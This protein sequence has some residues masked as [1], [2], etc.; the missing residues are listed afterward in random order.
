ME[1]F[2]E[3][4]ETIL[5]E[6][7]H[8]FVT[9]WKL[10][11]RPFPKAELFNRPGLAVSWANI[12]FAFYNTVFLT[13]QLT[14]ALVLK[15]RVQEAAAYMRAR[16]NPG[17]L[18]VC[19]DQLS[20]P[21]KD[22]LAVIMAQER[23]APS[24]PMTGMV[25]DILPLDAPVNPA[26]RFVRISDEATIRACFE[27]NCVS[28]HLPME[29]ARSLV[30]EH[31]LWQQHAY[32]FVA[33]EEDWPVATATT[34]V[35]EDCLF[36]FMVATMPE[37]RRKGYAEAV[38]RHS[39]NTAYKGTGIRRTVLHSTVAGYPLY[40][41]LGYEPTANFMGYMMEEEPSV[42]VTAHKPAYDGGR[43]VRRYR[44]PAK[45]LRSGRSAKVP[46]FV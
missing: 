12:S 11:G 2:M 18:I 30:G 9:T 42:E 13:E 5:A 28:Y 23:L 44:K 20:G 35:N 39:L 43:S 17:W 25:G 6:S 24:V 21:A 26:L 32:G 29:S 36:L 3:Q 27:I 37:A 15:D 1:E 8:Q 41:R 38:V 31:T 33:Y 22:N 46:A 19:L 4:T 10:I 14:D 7:L 45:E 40:L 16:Q 34:I